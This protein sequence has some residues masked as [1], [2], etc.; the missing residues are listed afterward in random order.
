MARALGGTRRP[1]RSA[2]VRRDRPDRRRRQGAAL[3]HGTCPHGCGVWMSHGDAVSAGARRASPS[4]PARRTPRSPRSRTSTG[5]WPACSTTP[6]WC[7]PS[8]A[9]RCCAGSCYDVAGIAP[10]WNPQ[11][12]LDEQVAAIRAVVGAEKVICGLSGGVD[13]AVAA[14]LVHRAVGDQL[15]CVFVDHGLLRAGEREQVERDYVAATGIKLVTVDAADAVPRRRWPASPSRRPSARSS[16]GSSSGSS[17]RAA[18][19]HQRGRGRGEVPG[20]GHP[21]PGRRRVRRRHRHRHHQVAPQRRRPAGGPAVPAGRAAAH[22]VQGRGP[23]CSAPNSACPRRSSSGTRSPGRAW[24]SGS[25][26]RSTR[27][28]SRCC[29]PPTRS[30]A[31]R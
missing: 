4:P 16:A 26:A 13:S 8:S 28:A 30:S 15:T 7:T 5:G 1:D 2:G 11:S 22:A 14:A 3:L 9:R 25:S 12:I 19:Q 24:A 21:V 31:R 23:G 29:A 10:D 18:A 27:T 20:A 6:R 17:R